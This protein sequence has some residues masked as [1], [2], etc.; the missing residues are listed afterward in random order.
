MSPALTRK[1]G[2][3]PSLII[4]GAIDAAVFAGLG[5]APDPAVAALMLA[6]RRGSPSPCGTS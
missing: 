1:L 6:R 4:A 3:L 2:M 5:L